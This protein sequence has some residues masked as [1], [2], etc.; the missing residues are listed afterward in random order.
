MVM[1]SVSLSLAK[2]S[3]FDRGS[4]MRAVERGRRKALSRYGAY[5][6]KIA[7]NSMK[8]SKK[9]AP[10][11]RPPHVHVGLLKRHIYFTY[12]AARQ[13]VVIG[14]ILIKAGSIVPSLLEHGGNVGKKVYEARPYMRPAHRQGLDKLRDFLKDFVTGG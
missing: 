10:P 1:L 6:R 7:Q 14:P 12:D 5:V 13:S 8:R 11:G 2:S 4:V 3:F 9:P